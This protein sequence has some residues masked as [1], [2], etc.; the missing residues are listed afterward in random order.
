MSKSGKMKLT[1]LHYIS[2]KNH[3]DYKLCQKVIILSIG[4][5]SEHK[6]LF[7]LIQ[8]YESTVSMIQV[9]NL[10]KLRKWNNK[11]T[12]QLFKVESPL[13]NHVYPTSLPIW[14][15]PLKWKQTKKSHHG[16]GGEDTILQSCELKRPCP[17]LTLPT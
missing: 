2:D 3:S 4:I 7:G 16:S 6:L 10:A 8:T 12:I 15:S 5:Y 9:Y 17:F 11:Y 13:H 14:I 1:D